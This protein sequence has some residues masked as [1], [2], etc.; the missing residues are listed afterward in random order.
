[1]WFAKGIKG[2]MT[3]H[4][5][6]ITVSVEVTEYTKVGTAGAVPLP[7]VEALF[8]ELQEHVKTMPLWERT[9]SEKVKE[10]PLT[11][12]ATNP[13]AKHTHNTKSAA[14]AEPPSSYVERKLTEAHASPTVK[15]EEAHED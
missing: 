6:G 12:K 10:E 8:I 7:E 9:K 13:W 1:M 2:V 5:N 14:L 11:P 15:S 3:A 4:G